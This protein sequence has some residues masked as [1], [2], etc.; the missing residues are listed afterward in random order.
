MLNFNKLEHAFGVGVPVLRVVPTSSL[1]VPS[2]SRQT[3]LQLPA[4]AL[5]HPQPQR[6][7]GPGKCQESHRHNANQ[8]S[9]GLP[10]TIS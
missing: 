9:S 4:L 5:R 7:A 10:G 3:R 2:T 8:L 6:Q 1:R